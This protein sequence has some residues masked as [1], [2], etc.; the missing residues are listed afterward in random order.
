[1]A[2]KLKAYAHLAIA[3]VLFIDMVGCSKLLVNEQREVVDELTRVFRKT[4]QFVKV[5]QRSNLFESPWATGG[6]GVLPD[7]G[8]AGAM[9]DGNCAPLKNHPRIRV[10]MGVHS[11][12]VDQVRN[13]ND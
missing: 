3:H 7:A 10:R 11:G 6:A 1:M 8:S 5:K 13:V 4:A 9:C 2:A 12:R